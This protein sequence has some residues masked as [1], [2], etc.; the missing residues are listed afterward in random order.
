MLSFVEHWSIGVVN[1]SSW[2]FIASSPTNQ[3]IVI[4]F[5]KVYQDL[6]ASFFD[7]GFKE[8]ANSVAH[9][10]NNY[11]NCHICKVSTY[12]IYLYFLVRSILLLNN[13]LTGVGV[14][15]RRVL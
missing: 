8:R 11:F 3:M 10:L 4:E 13:Y 15:F 5:L 7:N 2:Q 14:D 1:I 9:R 6:S 12:K